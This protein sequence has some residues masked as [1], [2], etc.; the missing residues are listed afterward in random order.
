MQT[1]SSLYKQILSGNH[2][3]EFSI[4]INGVN[5]PQSQ[6]KSLSISNRLFDDAPSIGN[7]IAG[8][9]DVEILTPTVTIPRMASLAPK[10]RVTN[11][12]STSEW[13]SKGT[14]F[15]DTRENANGVLTI[16]GYDSML[17]TEADFVDNSSYPRQASLVAADIATAIG[18]TVDNRTDLTGITV[19]TLPVGYS[20]REV[21][22]N[23]A[24]LACGNW[25]ISD[26]NALLLVDMAIP[27]ETNLL[28]TETGDVITFG[29]IGVVIG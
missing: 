26:D 6:I 10:L 29:G 27:G 17:K 2:W 18:V 11:G 13:I 15:I 20:Q 1:I 23:I 8:E 5:Y 7:T 28:I 4:D 25:V 21:L 3:Y 12:V 16:H 24:V 9:I 19:P 14:Y 22:A